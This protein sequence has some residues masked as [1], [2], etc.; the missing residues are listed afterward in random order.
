MRLCATLT[1][2]SRI[3]INREKNRKI[4]TTEYGQQINLFCRN[5]RRIYLFRD[6]KV[7]LSAQRVN[8]EARD[9]AISHG[10]NHVVKELTKK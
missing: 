3:S 9:R 4:G 7:R 6:T 10:P 8:L 2:D 5:D 1:P